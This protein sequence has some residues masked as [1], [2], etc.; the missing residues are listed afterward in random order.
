M[1]H[2]TSKATLVVVALLALGTVPAWAQTPRSKSR[3]AATQQGRQKGRKPKT[4]QAAPT[5][6]PEAAP[7][8]PAP[9]TELAPAAVAPTSTSQEPAKERPWAKGVPKKDQDAALELFRVG[10][11]LLKESIFV[12]A[13]DKYRQALELWDHPAIHYNMALVLMNLD[14]PLEVHEHL[15]AALRYGP[16]P[17]EAEK[18][19]Y[20]RNYKALIE[21]QLAR[22]DISCQEVG[23]TVTLDGKTLFVAPGRY[24]GLVRP[25]AH[26]IIANR[27]GYLPSDMSRT[28]LPGETATLDIKL[29]T[30]EDLIEY[31]R[32]W[33]TATPWL[34]VGSGVAVA[35][36]SALLHL[37]ARD[38]FQAYDTGIIQCGGCVPSSNV[39]ALR[40][41]GTLMQTLAIGGYAAGGAALVTGAVL[42][43]LNQ[44][45]PH[46]IDP[47]Q[48]HVEMSVAPLLGGGT[49][50]VQALFRF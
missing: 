19:E 28:L 24:T 14:Q 21:K 35:A 46:R 32:R 5:T 48:K 9:T 23:A 42:A 15:E 8:V 6:A 37:Q 50:G 10:N 38:S 33:P 39:S 45:Q 17:L 36:G 2:D 41:R 44:P 29:Y 3:T 11:G 34:V 4:Q 1:R 22:V 18:Y 40:A 20:A 26:N 47:T 49:R 31:R 16:D 12:Q 25:G 7:A 30:S 43:I 13:A 27:Q